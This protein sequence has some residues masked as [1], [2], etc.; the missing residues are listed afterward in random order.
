MGRV[1]PHIR[2]EKPVSEVQCKRKTE[3]E[4]LFL[5]FLSRNIIQLYGIEIYARD[6]QAWIV[7]KKEIDLD[8][9]VEKVSVEITNRD[10]RNTARVLRGIL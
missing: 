3:K 4:I 6:F 2:L 1:W 9:S 7:N 8:L 5:L 10:L